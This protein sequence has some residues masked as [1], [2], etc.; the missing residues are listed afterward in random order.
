MIIEEITAA[1]KR[2]RSR[3]RWYI[4]GLWVPAP[5]RLF[6]DNPPMHPAFVEW[7]HKD[8]EEISDAWKE[9]HSEPM[10][11]PAVTSTFSKEELRTDSGINVKKITV[12]RDDG[13]FLA[14]RAYLSWDVGDGSC[15]IKLV[16]MPTDDEFPWT[17][18]FRIEEA[19][20]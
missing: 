5:R 11:L 9:T 6:P 13:Y 15:N 8:S 19:L 16:A 4:G 7:T 18:A 14:F 12:V 20:A 17:P 3:Y 2:P 10:S 1:P